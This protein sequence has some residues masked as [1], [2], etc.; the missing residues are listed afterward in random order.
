M[1]TEVKTLAPAF[2]SYIILVSYLPTLS[3]NF[4]KCKMGKIIL[5]MV[6]V[7]INVAFNL[8]PGTEQM[9]RFL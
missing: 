6:V 1:D 8:V 7:K 2:C 5:H 4:L 3:V 9:I